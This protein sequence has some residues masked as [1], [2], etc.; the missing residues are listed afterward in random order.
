MLNVK[1]TDPLTQQFHSE[2]FIPDV[3]EYQ[4]QP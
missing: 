2:E 1:S 4:L 3:N